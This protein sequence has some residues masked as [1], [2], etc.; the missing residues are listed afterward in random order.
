MPPVL[1]QGSCF[2][3]GLELSAYLLGRSLRRG[4]IGWA[5][6]SRYGLMAA[7]L[8]ATQFMPGW[9]ADA[10]TVGG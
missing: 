5:P 3:F 7:L 10:N 1:G 8:L 6:A 2:D 9:G 4:L